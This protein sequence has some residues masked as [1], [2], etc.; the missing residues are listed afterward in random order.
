VGEPAKQKTTGY[1]VG[2]RKKFGCWGATKTRKLDGKEIHRNAKDFR[3]GGATQ[4]MGR[5]AR[6][7]RKQLQNSLELKH[8]QQEGGIKQKGRCCPGL[9]MNAV[10]GSRKS[11]PPKSRYRER[12][13][14]CRVV[15]ERSKGKR[16][17]LSSREKK[18]QPPEQVNY[19]CV[20]NKSLEII[21]RK[22]KAK[23]TK[24]WST[25]LTVKTFWKTVDKKLL[26][27]PALRVEKH[28]SVTAKRAQERGGGKK[29][30]EN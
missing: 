26:V 23:M 9:D 6:E 15:K 10:F 29:R 20:G 21:A 7:S 30:M 19:R 25:G 3:S 5:T 22:G 2:A 24:K 17:S 14:N 13:G 11:K 1:R 8:K 18:K 16:G 27:V 28:R 4:L 12:S